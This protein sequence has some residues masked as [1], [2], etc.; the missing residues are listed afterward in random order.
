[1]AAATLTLLV[2]TLTGQT[3][4]LRS[5]KPFVTTG[6]SA[7]IELSALDD[8]GRPLR[9]A[10]VTLT[11][12]VGSLTEPVPTQDGTLTATF[13]PPTQ[14]GPQVALLHAMVKR[15]SRDAQAWLA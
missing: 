6:E 10:Q 1:M 4:A 14:E 9:D 11:V 15:G 13:H 8:S 3:V 7:K 5:D 2:L 12:N